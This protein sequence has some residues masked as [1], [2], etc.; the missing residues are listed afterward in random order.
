MKNQNK[1]IKL[2]DWT[3]FYENEKELKKDLWNYLWYL[4]S[5]KQYKKDL[6]DE[7]F[8]YFYVPCEWDKNGEPES[9]YFKDYD[10]LS[11]DDLFLYIE[12]SWSKY[13]NIWTFSQDGI[14]SDIEFH[15]YES[16]QYS[17]YQRKLLEIEKLEKEIN[18]E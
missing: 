7:L 9:W 18:K 6:T 13:Y 15:S 8:D 2:Q 17:Q 11:I 5:Q 1:Y 10:A 16:N 4:D 12:Q 3:C 14:D